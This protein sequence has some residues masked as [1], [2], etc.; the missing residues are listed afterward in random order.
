[1]ILDF[2]LSFVKWKVARVSMDYEPHDVY[3]V[4]TVRPG[5]PLGTIGTGGGSIVCIGG[6]ELI[7]RCSCCFSGVRRW[8]WMWE[9]RSRPRPRL[10]V[11]LS[12]RV[13]RVFLTFLFD[14][15]NSSSSNMPSYAKLT[16]FNFHHELL[17]RAHWGT[18]ESIRLH[19]GCPLFI[20]HFHN[21]IY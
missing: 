9:R 14:N 1:M 18:N 4:Y 20:H 7:G 6:A 8:G 16:F 19:I 21:L 12:W 15:Q 2:A 10:D 17:I 3:T 13:C 11:W 5:T